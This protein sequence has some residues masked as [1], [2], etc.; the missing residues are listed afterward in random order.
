MHATAGPAGLTGL[1]NLLDG[2]VKTTSGA[3]MW[4]S[5]LPPGGEGVSL[6]FWFPK[7]PGLSLS[8]ITLWNYNHSLGTLALGVK[9]A[10]I[11]FREELVWKGVVKKGCG[12]SVNDYGFRVAI[13]GAE[14]ELETERDPE[15][16]VD[17]EP[18]PE[19]EPQTKPEP[20]PEAKTETERGAVSRALLPAKGSAEMAEKSPPK[21]KSDARNITQRTN[22]VLQ[23]SRS[24]EE[25]CFSLL[26][27]FAKFAVPVAPS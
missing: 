22:E 13:V 4:M 23:L 11:H 18:E 8:S 1:T 26:Q 9:E 7:H 20:S 3:H 17:R 5:V 14:S 6:N 21:K 19:V 16:E 2:S 25:L 27:P 10:E 15:P 12:N 24:S